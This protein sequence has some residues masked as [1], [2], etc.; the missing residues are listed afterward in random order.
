MNIPPIPAFGDQHF[1]AH[2]RYPK[3]VKVVNWPQVDLNGHR[4]IEWSWSS[5]GKTLTGRQADRQAEK[6]ERRRRSLVS[7]LGTREST[8]I[9]DMEVVTKSRLLRDQ[10]ETRQENMQMKS[11]RM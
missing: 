9:N 8:E 11:C 7:V 10:N 2:T 4:A 6:S 3:R 5:I 1:I